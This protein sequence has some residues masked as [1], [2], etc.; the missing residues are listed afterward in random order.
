M[1][2]SQSRLNDEIDLVYRLG[3]HGWSDLYIISNDEVHAFRITHVISDPMSELI[4]L[5]CAL[6]RGEDRHWVRLPDEP[7]GTL[8]DVVR[9]KDQRHIISVKAYSCDEWDVTPPSGTLVLSFDMKVRQFVDVMYHQFDKLSS[10]WKEPSYQRDRGDF[11]KAEF[12]ALKKLRA[13]R[14][15]RVTGSTI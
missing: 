11:P 10:L 14:S 9:H 1:P 5:C 3:K 2:R 12:L 7:G 8:I 15:R 13:A 6:L 4:E